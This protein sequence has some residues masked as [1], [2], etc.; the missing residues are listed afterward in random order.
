LKKKVSFP[1]EINSAVNSNGPSGFVSFLLV[2][3][4]I[5]LIAA[6]TV[7]TALYPNNSFFLFLQD[8]TIALLLSLTTCILVLKL[9]LE[10]AM[11]TCIDGV[12]SIVMIILIIAAGGAF[13]QILIDSGI[14]ELLKGPAGS[15]QFSP[16]F[17]GWMIAAVLRVM[18]GSATCGR[19]HCVRY[20]VS[21]DYAGH[22]T[23]TDGT[24]RWLRKSDVFACK[25]YRFLDV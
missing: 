17:L 10:Q 8:P 6:G 20:C 11:N 22:I 25:R 15:M 19:A 18:L 9:P 4:P 12:K 7:G 5:I 14:G 24:C 3:L 2:L 16:L 1:T 21:L 13:K 23:R